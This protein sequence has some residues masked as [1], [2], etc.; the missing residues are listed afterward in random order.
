[1]EY[2]FDDPQFQKIPKRALYCGFDT[3]R[4]AGDPVAARNS[5]CAAFT[6]PTDVR[7]LLFA[8]RT[9]RG[10]DLG[11]PQNHKNSGFAVRLGIEAARRDPSIRLLMC[12]APSKATPILQARI[13]EAGCSERIVMAG[14]RKDIER[15]MLA[16]DLLL[17]PSRGEGLGM[18]AVEAQAAGLPVLASTSV[19]KECLVVQGMVRFLDVSSDLQPWIVAIDDLF[20]REKCDRKACNSS[21]A[22]SAFAICNS[23]EQLERVYGF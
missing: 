4:F 10:S 11:H 7:I 5:I 17:F 19:P 22:A 8:G 15:F 23:A 12:G 13:D 20:A 16:A 21:V 2:G 1:M 3:D 18:V 14:I 6:W 9:D